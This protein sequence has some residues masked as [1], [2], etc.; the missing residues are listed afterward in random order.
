MKIRIKIIFYKKKISKNN[1]ININS[2]NNNKINN[3]HNNK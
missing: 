3:S 1:K 2:S